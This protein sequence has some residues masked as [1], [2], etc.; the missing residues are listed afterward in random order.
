MLQ[1]GWAYIV[2]AGTIILL[3]NFVVHLMQSFTWR[4]E[5]V[6]EETASASIL[7]TIA[8]PIAYI[9]APLVGVVAWQF[10]AACVTGFIAKENV[11]ATLA[12]CF[13]ISNLFNLDELAMAE[14]STGTVAATFGITSVAALSFLVFNLFSPPC[15]AAIGAMNA[16]LKSKKWL[17]AGIGMQLGVG[18]TLAFLVYFFG[19]LLSGEGFTAAWM[20]ILGWSIVLLL[21]VLV[22]F[23]A[24]KQKNAAREN[25]REK[26]AAKV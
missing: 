17:F 24:L 15:F 21:S 20:P 11:V 14:G 23:L 5:T 3:C 25:S 2:K 16:E 4:L 6:T 1:R 8:T 7:A 13:G 26:V 19:T 18:Y 22:V 12:V 10:A 9:V